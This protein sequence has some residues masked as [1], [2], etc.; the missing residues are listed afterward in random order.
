[1]D[2]LEFRRQILS[3][4]KFRNQEIS[5]SIQ[6]AKANQKFAD[7]VL[8]LDA[9]IEQA[10]KID[11]PDDLA[12]RI[13]FNQS[14]VNQKKSF[15]KQMLAMAASV[16]FAA[17]LIVGQINWT[18]LLVGSAHASLADTAV[19]HVIHE[20]PFV[21]NLDEQVSS[22]QINAK[23]RPFA[24]QFTEEFPYH[25]YYLNHCGF[26]KSNALHVI[27]QGDKG[28]VTLFITN[29]TS[30][31]AVDFEKDGMS[32]K[33]IPISEASVILVGEEGENIPKIAANLTSIIQTRL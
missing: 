1:M 7:D 18:P 20:Y 22:E 31:Q 26:G 19:E 12:D 24:Y 33:V 13:L 6:Y 3:E 16:A 8:D 9:K 32:G 23:L 28:K 17:G 21:N 5:D 14:T 30:E 27:F 25:V 10:M 4:P 11:V 15:T 2:E 29:K